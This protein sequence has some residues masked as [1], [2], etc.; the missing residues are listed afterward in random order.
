MTQ[1][2]KHYTALKTY[3]CDILESPCIQ[4]LEDLQWGASP[5]NCELCEI[6]QC[7]EPPETE[8]LYSV[9]TIIPGKGTIGKTLAEKQL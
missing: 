8:E 9:V 3:Y 4:V 6:A 1:K 7:P 2:T 5:P